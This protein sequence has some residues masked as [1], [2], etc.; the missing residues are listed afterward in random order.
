MMLHSMA[1]WSAR[2]SCR[3]R[4]R[5]RRR[6]SCWPVTTCKCPR[7][8]YAKEPKLDISLLERLYDHYPNDFPCKKFT[9][10]L[11]YEQKLITSGKQLKHERFVP[12]WHST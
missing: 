5:R 1:P 8:C 10:E 6:A 12:R 9:S 3:W 11:F 2:R 4:W 7:S